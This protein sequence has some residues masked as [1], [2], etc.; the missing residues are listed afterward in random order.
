[1]QILPSMTIST[2]K[3]C[4]R[5]QPMRPW[6][7]FNCFR[8][9]GR[10][11]LQLTAS[12]LL[13]QSRCPQ[14]SILSLVGALSGLPWG[15]GRVPSSAGHC[16]APSSCTSVITGPDCD[17]KYAPVATRASAVLQQQMCCGCLSMWISIS[18]SI[19]DVLQVL[20]IFTCCESSSIK[21]VSISGQIIIMLASQLQLRGLNVWLKDV[22]PSHG[23]TAMKSV[24]GNRAER[25]DKVIQML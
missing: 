1:M 23:G 3:L 19:P 24:E 20:V 21:T 6:S 2:L 14:Q 18:S 25:A 17:G 11:T 8:G 7:L 4:D 13:V 9:M 15:S 12:H 22:C 16:L 10:G 5:N